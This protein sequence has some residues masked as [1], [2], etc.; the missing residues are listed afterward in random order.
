MKVLHLPAETGTGHNMRA[1]AVAAKVRSLFPGAEQHVYLGSKSALFTPMFEALDVHV[2]TASDQQDHAN[3]SQ[4]TRRFDWTSYVTGY[5][6]RTFISGDRMLAAIALIGSV[7]PDVVVSDY[8]V[9]A[10]LAAEISGVPYV[11]ITERYDFTLGQIGN[12]ALLDAGFVLDDPDEIDTIRTSLTTLFSWVTR[13]ARVVLTDK[14]S[15]PELDRG[16]PVFEAIATGNGHVIGPIVRD[17]CAA[18][19]APRSE[20]DAR[21]GLHGA[22]YAIV[23][24]GGTTMFTENKERMLRAYLAAFDQLRAVHPDAR[25]VVIGRQ[26][27]TEEIDGVVLVDYVSDWHSL[28]KHAKVV[29]S[30][31]GWLSVTE[32]AVM[33][34]PVA[35]VLSGRDE[36]H[37]RE[38]MTRLDHLGYTTAIEPDTETLLA[39]LRK[40]FDE[41]ETFRGRASE[42]SRAI[43]PTGNGA[44]AAAKLIGQVVAE[45]SAGREPAEAL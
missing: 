3:T 11:L 27:F 32:L 20:I 39:I 12:A 17:E 18:E 38:A 29:L 19:P 10:C 15:V 43:A 35:Y 6:N 25:L 7:R 23:G 5:L 28:V 31:P 13:R 36:Y 24:F 26:T 1:L 21:F 16:T 42:A 40:A 8:N 45:T 30:P 14:P 9:A 37:E 22:E 44:E 2:H 41:P 34:A 4:L 33:D